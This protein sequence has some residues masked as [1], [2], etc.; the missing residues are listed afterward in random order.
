MSELTFLL[1]VR[2]NVTVEDDIQ[3][4]IYELR[5]LFPGVVATHTSP[6]DALRLEPFTGLE[7]VIPVLTSPF[8]GKGI[9]AFTATCPRID[10]YS[11]AR[12]LSYIQEMLVVGIG[13]DAEDELKGFYRQHAWNS[14]LYRLGER[15]I[16]RVIPLFC[17]LECADLAVKKL[18]KPSEVSAV[19]DALLTELLR[20][21][22]PER[23]SPLADVP[24]KKT[25][26]YLGHNLHIYKAKFF[27][28]IVRSLINAHLLSFRDKRLFE[29]FVGSGT[30]LLEAQFLGLEAY[31]TD[32]DPLSVAMS[33]AKVNLWRY[34]PQLLNEVVDRVS[35]IVNGLKPTQQMVMFAEPEAEHE[36]TVELPQAIA[37]KLSA[38][39]LNLIN[40]DASA[41]KTAIYSIPMPAQLRELCLIG[42]SDALARK[43]RL[44]FLGTGH[45]RFAIEMRR[46]RVADLF[47]SHMQEIIR[48]MCATQIIS[49]RFG[50]NLEV[51]C[52]AK[53]GNALDVQ[54]EDSS[55]DL[56]ITSPPYLPAASGRE[57][58][59]LGKGSSLMALDLLEEEQLKQLN[60]SLVGSM[61]YPEGI[62]IGELPE[63]ARTFISWLEH[64]EVR[65][66]K[67]GPTLRYYSDIKR[68]FSEFMRVLRPGGTAAMVVARYHTFYTY[69]T[70][71]V[72]FTADNADIIAQIADS[73]GL[74]VENIINLRLDKLN[75]VARPRSQDDYFESIVVMKRPV[76][77][78]L[79]PERSKYEDLY[80]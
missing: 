51:S 34:D 64:D 4:A 5:H 36:K 59:T 55:V 66:I 46:D 50:L 77:E 76:L 3:L 41:I 67:A 70:R 69:K 49:E 27:P 24:T 53:V 22:L 1:K 8:R 47:L 13:E 61:S 78:M 10:L 65:N 58:Y 32:L 11:L 57:N 31:G 75:S 26:T 73:L 7:Q 6:Q 21:N 33:N 15:T 12:R 63:T 42:L 71:E 52:E 56:I 40:G 54:L 37:K 38:D 19:L 62:D 29:P 14:R 23:A 79:Q 20:E 44:R 35:R 9:G 60:D 80:V 39:D 17:I 48:T 74:I 43:L 72:V 18:K 28:R 2:E 30:A 25:S 68:V 16:L 45:G